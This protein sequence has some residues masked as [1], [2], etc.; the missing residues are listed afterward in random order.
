M[1]W[2]S[3]SLAALRKGIAAG[4][5]TRQLMEVFPD[6]SWNAIYLKAWKLGL[7]IA[8]SRPHI[9]H[10]ALDSYLKLRSA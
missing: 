3:E 5:T 9:N 1:T 6:R 8:D 7:K 4:L 10:A 2:D